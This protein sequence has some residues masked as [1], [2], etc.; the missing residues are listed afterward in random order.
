MSQ[1]FPT[2]NINAVNPS[3]LYRSGA[4]NALDRKWASQ[5]GEMSVRVLAEGPSQPFF[6]SIQKQES[7]YY[8]IDIPLNKFRSIQDLHRF[9]DVRFYNEHEFQ[10][11]KV[12]LDYL[13]PIIPKIPSNEAYGKF[14]KKQRV[15]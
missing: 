3:Y 15:D 12:G 5:L 4:P 9:V 10:I 13:A 8:L 2:R 14:G 7:D 1:Y 11:S 6:L